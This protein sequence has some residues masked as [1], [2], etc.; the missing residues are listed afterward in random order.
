MKN[1]SR[2]T[3]KQHRRRR[4][5]RTT[6]KGGSANEE[7]LHDAVYDGNLRKVMRMVQQGADIDKNG[8]NNLGA[9][10][11]MIAANNGDLAIVRYLVEQ[12]ADKEKV[13]N[14]G[15]SPLMFA[16]QEGHMAVVRYLVEQGVD[17]NRADHDG[18]TPLIIAAHE[19][20]LDIVQYLVEQ[21]V[22]KNQADHEGYTPLM[23]AV[24]EG[25]MAVVRYLVEQGADKENALN[26]GT[27]PLMLAIHEGNMAAVV[28]YLVEQ[29][30]DKNR[31]DHKGYTPLMFAAYKGN[32]AVVRY[33]V[34]QG[35]YTNAINDNGDTAET[36]TKVEEIKQYL[37]KKDPHETTVDRFIQAVDEEGDAK[38]VGD[39]LDKLV[40]YIR[41][42]FE[43]GQQGA[44]AFIEHVQRICNH[45]SAKRVLA[46][47]LA[48]DPQFAGMDIDEYCLRPVAA[49]AELYQEQLPRAKRTRS[50][51]P[52]PPRADARPNPQPVITE[53]AGET[54]EIDGRPHYISFLS[55]H[56]APIT[57][58]MSKRM[59]VGGG[60]KRR[61]TK[62]QKN[63][64]VRTIKKRKA[65]IHSL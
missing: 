24:Q 39:V 20:K 4:R 32:V 54:V 38:D 35:A 56:E 9:T 55:P 6:R 17:K 64:G 14:D 3:K 60:S 61:M 27:T 16:I 45:P 37:R 42:V 12:G 33:L 47:A 19:G 36:L 52:S 18:N 50:G 51:P 59:R 41:D 5:G 44:P 23:L 62:K 48:K 10:P 40:A 53:H 13:L 49:E 63:K 7:T 15:T 26:D 34:E 31:A 11:L 30:V 57:A 28:R 21:G 8:N 65:L 25:D 1:K 2:S 29:G 22:D 46:A 58:R 43:S